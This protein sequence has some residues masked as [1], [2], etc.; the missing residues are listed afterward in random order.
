MIRERLS[1]QLLAG[2]PARTPR[3]VVERILAVQAQDWRG[4]LLAV[5]ARSLGLTAAAVIEAL[6]VD[7]SLVISWLNRGTLHLVRS[8]DYSWLL[9]LTA[10][11]Q[12]SGAFTR[13]AQEGISASAAEKGVL[14]VTKAL[15]V[16][17]PMTRGQLRDRLAVKGVA[18]ASSVALQL[19]FLASQRGLIVRGPRVGKEQAFVLVRDWLG[20]LA[21]PSRE[22][23]LTELALRYLSGHAPASDRDLA[24]WAGVPLRDVRAGLQGLGSEIKVRPDGLLE[25]GR[26]V[27]PAAMP[28]PRLLGPFDPVL[29]GWISRQLVLGPH[30]EVVA[31]NGLFRAFALVNGRAVGTWGLAGGTV[32]LRPFGDIDESVQAV[33]AEDARSVGRF[34]GLP[35]CSMTVQ[36]EDRPQD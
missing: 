36:R 11:P 22:T 31:V 26:G 24:R 30:Q 20:E 16:H 29:L 35:G 10:R 34:L 1:S 9:A 28:R 15:A 21:T 27:L 7:R 17:G 23:S 8:E 4:M 33:L 12:H 6:V 19:L 5:R 3:A 14:V 2:P 18:R 32:T 13:L 25:L